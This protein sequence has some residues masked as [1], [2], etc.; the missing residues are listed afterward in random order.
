MRACMGVCVCACTRGLR[1]AVIS[2]VAFRG[3]GFGFRSIH[4]CSHTV[5][6]P[7]I[8]P[9][10]FGQC[11]LNIY[12][13]FTIILNLLPISLQVFSSIKTLVY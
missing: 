9:K 2:V 8:S 12:L 4:G 11:T 6:K 13:P 10:I 7:W 5:K 1:G 3:N